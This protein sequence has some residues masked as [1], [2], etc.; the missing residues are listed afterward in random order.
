MTAAAQPPYFAGLGPQQEAA[1]L[2]WWHVIEAEDTPGLLSAGIVVGCLQNLDSADVPRTDKACCAGMLVSLV[3]DEPELAEA[4][5]RAKLPGTAKPCCEV[6][7]APAGPAP[8]ACH[9]TLL[10]QR[11]Y[12]WWLGMS[13]ASPLR[14]KRLPRRAAHR[15]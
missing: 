1:L 11:L 4:V 15:S 8:R 12:R 7:R 6:R 5:V 13:F 14:P 10:L 2:L 9:N 3:K